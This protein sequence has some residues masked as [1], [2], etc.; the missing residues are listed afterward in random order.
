MH[1]HLHVTSPSPPSC[2]STFVLGI[3]YVYVYVCVCVGVCVCVC[4]YKCIRVSIY[5]YINIDIYI[6]I[7]IY[8]GCRLSFR[9]PERANSSR[10]NHSPSS[11]SQERSGRDA[12]PL[13]GGPERQQRLRREPQIH[14][15]DLGALKTTGCFKQPLLETAPQRGC[16]K[17]PL[18]E[19]KTSTM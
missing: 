11:A 9:A 5:I 4:V 10:W 3:L 18:L 19:T 2:T 12:A 1:L 15:R 16:F 8:S 13:R 14:R 17:Q 7:H 6:H